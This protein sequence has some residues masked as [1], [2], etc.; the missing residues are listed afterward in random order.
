MVFSDAIIDTKKKVNLLGDTAVGKTSLI[1]RFV[2]SVFGEEYLKTIG[3]NVYTKEVSITGANVKLIINDIMGE[4]AYRAVQKGAFMGSTG[5]IAVVDVTRK[6]TLDGLID[7]WLPRYWELADRSNPII[8]AVNKDDLPDKEINLEILEDYSE[9]FC[10]VF[11]TSAKVGDNVEECF[12]TLAE[13]VAPNLQIRIQDIEDIIHSKTISNNKELIDALLA[14]ASELG[15]MPYEKREE[16]LVESGIDKFLLDQKD[17]VAL[18]IFGDV[19]DEEAVRFGKLLM[20]W[21]QENEDEYS[22]SAVQRL[23]DK[24]EEESG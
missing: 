8:L 6:E 5:A 1:L 2:K 7:D 21:Y 10:D 18:E 15:D 9:Y 19:G 23:L 3:T 20:Y 11:F 12:K 13:E 17:E 22:A 24:F 4:K 16:I 14:Y